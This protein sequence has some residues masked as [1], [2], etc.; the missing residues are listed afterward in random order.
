MF[1]VFFSGLRAEMNTA[2]NPRSVPSGEVRSARHT[3]GVTE[4]PRSRGFLNKVGPTERDRVT[5]PSLP[6]TGPPH[7]GL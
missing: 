1:P 3:L 4:P 2:I 5:R 6:R 7:D